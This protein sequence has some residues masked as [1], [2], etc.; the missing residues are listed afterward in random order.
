MP[1]AASAA[2]TSGRLNR[3]FTG[4]AALVEPADLG[5]S[6]IEPAIDCLVF[7]DVLE[8]MVDPGPSS[9]RLAEW[10]RE[11]GQVLACIPNIQHYSV[12]VR[13]LRGRWQYQAE[14]LLD[15]T[16]CVF[17]RESRISS[18]APGLHVFDIQPRSW[19]S[20]DFDK[21]QQVMAAVLTR[22]RSTGGFSP[23]KPRPSS[24]SCGRSVP[25]HL[26]DGW[27]SGRCWVRSSAASPGLVSLSVRINSRRP[28]SLPE[29]PCDSSTPYRALRRRSN[30]FVRTTVTLSSCKRPTLP[31]CPSSRRVQPAQVRLEVRRIRR[32]WCGSTCK[33]HGV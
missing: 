22:S 5:L 6:A 1:E 30:H 28:C 21:F 12:L 8:H 24:T 15:R 17:S 2:G 29:Q 25:K 16:H 13:L 33:S 32:K 7:G 20:A 4:D 18:P 14:G 23:R 19:P 27:S 10:V 3:V 9:R 31:S 26:R 11:N